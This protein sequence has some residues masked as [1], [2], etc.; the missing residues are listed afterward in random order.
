[1]HCMIL[2]FIQSGKPMQNGF[3]E[4]FSKILRTEI[5]DMYLFRTLSEVHVLTEDWRTEYNE[6][7]PHSSLGDI[8][9]AIYVRK[10][11]IGDPH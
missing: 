7:H 9:P 4:R 3:I 1:M 10:K 6:E 5:L 2:D 8:T 11:L